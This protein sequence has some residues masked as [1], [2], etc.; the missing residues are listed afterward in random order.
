MSNSPVSAVPVQWSDKIYTKTESEGLEYIPDKRDNNAP[1]VIQSQT[2]RQL[3]ESEPVNNI[4]YQYVY[5]IHES[6]EK[7]LVPEI[8]SGQTI[9]GLR[10]MTSLLVLSLTVV[11]IVLAAMGGVLATQKKEA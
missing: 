6:K 11:I 3:Q 7:E 4:K 1:E 10:R 8:P 9:C 2:P 5:K